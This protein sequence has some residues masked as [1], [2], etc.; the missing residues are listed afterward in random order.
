[1]LNGWTLKGDGGYGYRFRKNGSSL[2]NLY[3]VEVNR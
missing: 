2:Y 1:M 3:G